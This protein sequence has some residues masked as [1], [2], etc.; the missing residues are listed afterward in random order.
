MA[1]SRERR[2]AVD[3]LDATLL[4]SERAAPARTLMDVLGE[5]VAQYGGAEAID[6][7]N[8]RLT[9]DELAEAVAET[10]AEV[11]AG[12]IGPGDRVGVRVRSG[13]VSLH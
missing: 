7:G 6:I 8:D 12:G 11:N 5:I 1:P 2:S 10:A 9:Y 4:R 3:A 13:T